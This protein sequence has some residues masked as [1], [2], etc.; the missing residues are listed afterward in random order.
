MARTA[1]LLMSR[2]QPVD[3]TPSNALIR[4]RFAN[5]TRDSLASDLADLAFVSN[6]PGST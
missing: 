6:A 4:A 2:A 5:R 3:A 1:Q